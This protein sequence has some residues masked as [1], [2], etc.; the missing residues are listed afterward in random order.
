MKIGL[1][2]A[3]PIDG[4]IESGFTTIETNLRA[5]AE[6]G[7]EMVVFP[8]LYL[9][10]YNRPDLHQELAQ[11]IDG[12]WINRLTALVKKY[13]CGL[14]LGWAESSDN[15]VY[16]SAICLDKNGTQLANYRKIQLFGEMEKASFIPGDSYQT[17]DWNG[18]KAALLIC[19]D[20]EFPQHCRELAEMGVTLI[21]VPTAN[22]TG[23][24][25][26]SQTLVPAR[27]AEMGVTIVYANYCGSEAG[28]DYAGLSMIASS[29]SAPMA[30]VGCT[31]ALVIV[32]LDTRYAAKSISSTQ[33]NDYLEVK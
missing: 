32:D 27:A 18:E 8:E 19:Y 6:A 15:T 23:Y 10:G 12:D 14:T 26:V 4:D 9:P 31:P 17:F 13:G 29:D 16:N 7:A 1:C 21:F 11:S 33:L 3:L 22:P 20:I 30:M 25:Y 28:L 2:Q 5:A 24:E